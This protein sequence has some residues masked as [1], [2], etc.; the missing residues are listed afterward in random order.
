MEE[1]Q[2]SQKDQTYDAQNYTTALKK[3]KL[4]NND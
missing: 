4:Y 1:I 3:S 2:T